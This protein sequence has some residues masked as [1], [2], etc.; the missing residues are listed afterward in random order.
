MEQ[1][2]TQQWQEHGAGWA[3]LLCEHPAIELGTSSP[4]QA[5]TPRRSIVQ[6]QQL[7]GSTYVQIQLDGL[8][9]N[10]GKGGQ[11]V[12]EVSQSSQREHSCKTQG[13]DLLTCKDE[14]PTSTVVS[15]D[16]VL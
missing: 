11:S 10:D 1:T 16:P 6:I 2:Q 4:P 3:V 13:G 5:A 15:K 9:A 14:L 12:L 8:V 7:K